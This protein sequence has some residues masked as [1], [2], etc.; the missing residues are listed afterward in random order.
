MV[1][2][3]KNLKSGT[4]ILCF[5]IPLPPSSPA[6]RGKRK[7]FYPVVPAESVSTRMIIESVRS[8]QPD[9]DGM[10]ALAYYHARAA[11]WGQEEAK[12]IAA[13]S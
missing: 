6:R 10:R 7:Y 2:V 4:K 13:A 8:E 11:G 9:L 3:W 1:I 5:K 12:I